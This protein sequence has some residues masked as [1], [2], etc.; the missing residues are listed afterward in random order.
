MVVAIGLV[1]GSSP[2]TEA[3]LTHH[4]YLEGAI[5]SL[6]I[7]LTDHSI[8]SVQS[9][10]LLSIYYCCLSKPCHALDYCLIASLKVQ[11]LLRK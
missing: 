3:S 2:G 5:T 8:A 9:L 1:V 6:P 7:V 10:I 4:S 11:N